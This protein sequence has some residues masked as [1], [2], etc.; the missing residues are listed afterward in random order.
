M[1]HIWGIL[2]STAECPIVLYCRV[3]YAYGCIPFVYISN[4]GNSISKCA[5]CGWILE[6]LIMKNWF[7]ATAAGRSVCPVYGEFVR[8]RWSRLEN[9]FQLNLFSNIT[10]NM[11]IYINLQRKDNVDTCW[12]LEHLKSLL[13]VAFRNSHYPHTGKFYEV[14]NSL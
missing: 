10:P 14:N 12:D 3:V 8:D 1:V 13:K 6:G 7:C 9:T 11:G 5:C 2:H 4:P